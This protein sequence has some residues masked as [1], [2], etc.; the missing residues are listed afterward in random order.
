MDCG[1][2]KENGDW[3]NKFKRNF[4]EKSRKFNNWL[5]VEMK[6]SKWFEDF[7]ARSLALKQCSLKYYDAHTVENYISIALWHFLEKRSCFLLIRKLVFLLFFGYN[8]R[9]STNSFTLKVI[10]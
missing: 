4:K 2:S 6:E 8:L 9:H 5:N 3:S 10:V 1:G 7:Q